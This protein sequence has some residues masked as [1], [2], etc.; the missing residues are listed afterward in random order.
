QDRLRFPLVAENPTVLASD[1]DR[2]VNFAA[3]FASTIPIAGGSTD[4]GLS[5][6]HGISREARY[7]RPLV[8]TPSSV[9]TPG[10]DPIDQVGLDTVATIDQ[11]QLK[12]EGIA[13]TQ[14]GQ[15]YY[16]TVGGF[17]YTFTNAGDSGA[18]VGLVFE[19][20]TDDR[21]SVQPPTVYSR[22]IFTG[23]RL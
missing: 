15:Q 6:F 7:V 8:P 22:A 10:S 17:E 2:N 16:A 19:H 18:D 3:R 14:F 1:I 23:A 12:F 4:V 5:Y 21:S 11:L 9:M 20:L 13:R